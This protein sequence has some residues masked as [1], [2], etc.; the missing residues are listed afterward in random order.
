MAAQILD[1][2]QTVVTRAARLN[3]ETEGKGFYGF[4]GKRIEEWAKSKHVQ[5]K[6]FTTSDANPNVSK[7]SFRSVNTMTTERV[8]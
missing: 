6:A 3:P 8:S 7:S 5:T 2:G 1:D 4:M